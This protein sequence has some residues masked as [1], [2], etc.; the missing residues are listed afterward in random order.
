MLD[1]LIFL[2]NH[3]RLTQQ[4]VRVVGSQSV[5]VFVYTCIWRC[6]FRLP[7]PNFKPI[8]NK[9]YLSGS[10]LVCW[11]L[12]PNFP[13]SISSFFLSCLFPV[14]IF[15]ETWETDVYQSFRKAG[16]VDKSSK[17][18]RDGSEPLRTVKPIPTLVAGQS[19]IPS[20]PSFWRFERD[21][22]PE[23]RGFRSVWTQG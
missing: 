21:R 5:S 14:L 11:S 16:R 6:H 8:V 23:K 19:Q 13:T 22:L 15:S 1:R 12:S 9:V 4:V 10:M 7:K 2:T 3:H 20:L 18:Y 17:S